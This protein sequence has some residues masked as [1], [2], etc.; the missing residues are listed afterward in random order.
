MDGEMMV[1]VVHPILNEALGVH[2]VNDVVGGALEDP[3]GDVDA[4]DTDDVLA[5]VN[6][7]LTDPTASVDDILATDDDTLT[8]V[9][10][11]TGGD[12]SSGA[13]L[14]T[15]TSLPKDLISTALCTDCATALFSQVS[16]IANTCAVA[17]DATSDLLTDTAFTIAQ[18][19]V[20]ID[21]S[22]STISEILSSTQFFS[23]GLDSIVQHLVGGT[24]AGLGD[25]TDPLSLVENVP[26]DGGA[27]TCI[28]ES[29]LLEETLSLAQLGEVQTLAG[30]VVATC[31]GLLNGAGPLVGGVLGDVFAAVE[32]VTTGLIAQVLGQVVLLVGQVLAAVTA[33]T[34]GTPVFV[35]PLFL[36]GPGV[37]IGGGGGWAG[38]YVALFALLL[39]L[40]CSGIEVVSWFLGLIQWKSLC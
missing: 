40:F 10:D 5:D 31:T 37:G 38:V 32:G 18:Q 16:S 39:R 7:L 34:L 21:Q 11:I 2:V 25:V 8:A 17:I 28:F 22:M 12:V 6:N 19:V 4:V 27:F 30:G 1:P 13:P 23:S 36:A 20:S 9:D 15:I 14:D 3:A 26:V 33:V 35:A 29:A 24:I